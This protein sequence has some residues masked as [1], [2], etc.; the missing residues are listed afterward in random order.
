MAFCE[1]EYCVDSMPLH[2]EAKEEAIRR[3]WFCRLTSSGWVKADK[4]VPDINRVIRDAFKE[5]LSGFIY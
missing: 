1:F 3:G 5:S 2:V 4:G